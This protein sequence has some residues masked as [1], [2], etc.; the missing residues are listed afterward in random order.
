MRR[1]LPVLL[2]SIALAAAGQTAAALS[3]AD[4]ERIVDFSVTLK[5]LAAASDGTARLPDG[6]FV[7][8]NGTVSDVNVI[9]KEQASFRV[10][11]ELITGEWI[12][13][14]DVKSYSC[15][16]DFSGPEFFKVFPVR[17][18]RTPEEG[19][20]VIDSRVIVV[21][22]PVEVTKTPLGEKRVLVQGIFV[23]TVE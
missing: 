22:R 18:P 14:E 20:V 21:G 5:D 13:T 1:I 6:R 23:R 12:G 10:R 9:D 7:V 8:L 2:T 19:T 16:V 11:I 15:Y 4:F 17:P 3:R